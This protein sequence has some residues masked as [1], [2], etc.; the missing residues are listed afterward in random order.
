M[1]QSI[2]VVGSEQLHHF[3]VLKAILKKL[4]KPY[5]A[6][7]YHLSY[8]MVDLPSGKMKSREGTVVDADD[9]IQEMIATAKEHTLNLGKI[10]G[11]SEKEANK[12]FEIIGLGALKYYLLKVDA[13]KRLLFNPQES[14][15]FHGHTGP[16][17]QYSYTRIQS[18]LRKG[19][20]LKIEEIDFNNIKLEQTEKELIIQLE[21]F[22]KTL[23]DAAES[24]SPS[25]VANYVYTLA[26]IFN[27]FYAEIPVLNIED[28]NTLTFRLTLAKKAGEIIEQAMN[29]LCIEVP[30]RM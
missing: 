27:K 17:I 3:Q 10:D 28:K 20:N 12:L 15:D 30:N 9:L 14:I 25:I 19:N 6:G 22:T 5:A 7:V 11:F 4:Q 13:Q 21:F 23:V 1:D 26:K 2:Y 18:L 8:G 29:L 16:F 24:Y